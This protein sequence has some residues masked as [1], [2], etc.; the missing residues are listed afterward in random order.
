MFVQTNLRQTP[1]YLEH[2]KLK[3]RMV[4]FAG[5]D[6]PV[7]YVSIISEYEHTR[8]AA[9][10]FDTC[11]MGEFL[12]EGDARRS[13]LDKIVTQALADMPVKTCR[14][15]L[16]L[17]ESGGVLDDLIVFRLEK[18]KWM[19]VVNGGTIEKDY[20]QF[21]AHVNSESLLKN[22]SF[23]TGKLDLQGPLARD[24][25]RD[26]IPSVTK[27]KFYEF[28]YFSLL[29]ETALVSRT[30]YTGEL[31]YEI[32]FPWNRTAELWQ[33][34]LKNPAVKPAGLGARDVLR[35]EMGYHLYGQDLDETI[36][37][38]EAG[39]SRFIDF[40]K[41]FIGRKALLEE[42]N[43]GAQRDMIYFVSENRRSPRHHHKI[44]T[45]DL[46]E[47]GIVTSGTFSP[48]LARGIGIALVD[49]ISFAKREKI[50]FGEKEERFAARVVKRP[51]YKKGSLKN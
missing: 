39:L 11:H 19:I 17:N 45:E 22:I 16:L 26:F 15:G 5:W 6:M 33:A 30:G 7:Q 51:F 10:L 23:E 44:F 35:L 9:S 12:V 50:F 3:A 49:R 25:L 43:I 46:R 27:L 29:G 21:E 8:N 32:Y 48:S 18:E 1:L 41:D 2:A 28:D 37:P 40:E 20:Q 31:G 24:V 42:K 14:Y 38:L 13:G 34:L 36:S 47:I 4:P